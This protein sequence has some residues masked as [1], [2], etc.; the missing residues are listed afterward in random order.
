ME[1]KIERGMG[2]EDGDQ[3]EKMEIGE[4]T[5]EMRERKMEMGERKIL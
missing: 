2:K 1:K 3:E 5:M 4:R